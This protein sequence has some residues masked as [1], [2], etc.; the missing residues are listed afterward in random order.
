M[1]H[2]VFVFDLTD[3]SQPLNPIPNFSVNIIPPTVPSSHQCLMNNAEIYFTTLPFRTT[4]YISNRY[5]AGIAA[6][7]AKHIRTGLDLFRG[8]QI[9]PDGKYAAVG[10]Q[11]GG[12]I[13][14]YEII[15]SRGE[16]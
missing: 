10:G 13:E 8:L 7:S 4:F 5:E 2:N 6:D 16:E 3:I 15:G 9:T 14:I 1:Y 12:G 11:E